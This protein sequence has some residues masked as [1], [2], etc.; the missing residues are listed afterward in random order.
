MQHATPPPHRAQLSADAYDLLRVLEFDGGG[1]DIRALIRRM[2]L[3][4]DRLKAAIE[5]AERLGRVRVRPRAVRPG[6]PAELCHIAR[7]SMTP[8]GRRWGLR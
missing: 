2:A 8:L 7:V 3:P 1:C 5:E 4:P 6:L